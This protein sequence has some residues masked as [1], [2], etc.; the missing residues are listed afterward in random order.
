MS[1]GVSREMSRSDQKNWNRGQSGREFSLAF[2]AWH[3]V[4]S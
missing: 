2:N 4:L 1:C 3:M